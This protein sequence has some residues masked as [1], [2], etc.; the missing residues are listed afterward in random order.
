MTKR[1]KRQKTDCAKGRKTYRQKGLKEGGS[2]G[3]V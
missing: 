2:M 1:A 3:E